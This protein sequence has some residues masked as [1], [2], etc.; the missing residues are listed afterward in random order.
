MTA[1]AD[2]AIGVAEKI[3]AMLTDTLRPLK[4]TIKGWPADFRVIIWEALADIAS[5]H[6]QEARNS[7]CR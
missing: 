5:R 6:A 3:E 1:Q 4:A 7:I 2:K